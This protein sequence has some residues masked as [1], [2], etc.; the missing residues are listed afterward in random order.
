MS[1]WKKIGFGLI[2]VLF[3][4]WL[5]LGYI[6]AYIA[7]MPRLRDVP[8]RAELAGHPV[9]NILLGSEDGVVLSAWHVRNS[10]DR[11]VIFL[12]GIGADRR[13]GVS[14]A[15][16]YLD[17][18]YSVLLLD[19]RGTGKSDPARIT[20]GW[21]ERKDLTAAVRYLRQ[22]G[23]THIGAHGISLGAATIA[24]SLEEEDGYAFLVLESCYDTLDH[25]WRNRLKMVGV[26]HFITYPMRWFT[27]LRMGVRVG[28]VQPLAYMPY[29]KA[30]ILLMAGDSE[31]ELK[32]SETRRL[33]EACGSAGKRL[34]LF[35]GG[36]HENFLGRYP[37][38]FKRLLR[39]FLDDVSAPWDKG[40]TAEANAA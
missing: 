10:Q 25:A 13:Q 24:F 3:V 7:T 16:L 38:D 17:W 20:I 37:E 34:H 36:H 5:A 1:R 19:L 14:R 28:R 33:Y 2:A 29:C 22:Q 23:Y 15:N 11:A 4:V 9:E 12:S 39:A 31:P 30:P 40:D 32:V 6:G 26:P 8:G 35:P 27:Q 18:G 21:N